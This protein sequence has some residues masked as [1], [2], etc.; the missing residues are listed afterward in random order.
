MGFIFAVS[1]KERGSWICESVPLWRWSG[2]T[3]VGG[4]SLSKLLSES[5]ESH[6]STFVT[7]ERER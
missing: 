6:E 4:I 1:S 2:G 5:K 3:S 7:G